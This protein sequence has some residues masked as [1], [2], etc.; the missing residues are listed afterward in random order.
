MKKLKLEVDAVAVVSFPTATTHEA[1]GT[2]Q[3]H[4]LTPRCV[5]TGSVD[6]CWCTESNC[7]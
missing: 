1:R 3:A 2:V 7:P 6:S 5:V 4:V